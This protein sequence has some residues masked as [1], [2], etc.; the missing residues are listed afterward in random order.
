MSSESSASEVPS[1]QQALAGRIPIP[2]QGRIFHTYREFLL[3]SATLGSASYAYLVGA[4]LVMIGTTWIAILGYM[5]GLVISTAFVTYTA[6]VISYRLGVD[7]VDA[8][9]P[10]LGTRGAILVLIGVIASCAGW[11]NVLLAM[12]ARGMTSLATEAH[13]GAGLQFEGEV[14]AFGIALVALIWVLLRRGAKMMEKAASYCAIAQ[15]VLALVVLGLIAKKFGLAATLLTNVAPEKAY[16]TNK[17]LQLAYAVEFGLTNGLGMFA[18]VGGLARLVKHRR[19]V[20]GPVVAGYAVLG[21]SFV[22]A[23]GALAAAATG[24]DDLGSLLTGVAG[25]IVGG[26]VLAVIMITNVGTMVAQFYITGLA[27]QQISLFARLRWPMVVASVLVPSLVIAFNTQWLLDRVMAL[28]AY[29]GIMFVGVTA[30]MFV[31][32]YVLRRQKVVAAHLFASPGQGSYWFS[33]GVNWVAIFVIVL[34]S[35]LYIVFFDPGTLRVSGPFAMFGASIPT[36][37][38]GALAYYVLM[39]LVIARSTVGGYRPSSAKPE[40]VE[41]GL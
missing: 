38:V 11:A 7:A 4:S 5:L 18:F 16:T 40:S 15:I 39:R 23:V 9:K 21:A 37:T 14:I 31:D 2:S 35:A 13:I 34:T 32:Y 29:G 30:I 20:V 28:L 41:V 25:P 33:A 12:T 27:I 8:V 24:K 19:H 3:T 10:A 6:G 22:A 36:L 1:A 26:V 17:L